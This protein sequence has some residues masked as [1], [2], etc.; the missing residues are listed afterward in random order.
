MKVVNVALLGIG[1]VGTGVYRI[2][3]E[4]AADIKHREG[5]DIRIKKILVR[6]MNKKRDLEIDKNLYTEDFEDII[7]D[8]EIDIV[9]EFMGGV[10]PARDYIVKS[11]QKGKTVVT[12]NK[13]VLA[14]HWPDFEQAAKG[15]GAGLYFEAS[16][17]GGIPII[18]ALTESLQ[19]NNIDSIMGIING[20]TNYILTEMSEKDASYDDV[21]KEAQRQGLAE[22]DPAN[23]VEGY[24]AAY[25]LSILA[26]LAFHSRVHVENIFVEGIT[27]INAQD[28]T[29][30][31]ELGYTIKLLAIGK[32]NGTVIE[33]RVHPALI[34]QTHPL[35]SVRGAY[36]AIFLH[37]HALGNFMLYGKGAGEMPTASAIVSDIIYASHI[38]E[39]K[40]STFENTYKKPSA[41]TFNT[42]W[43]SEYFI[44]LKVKDKPGVLSKISG[45]FGN[46]GVSIASMMQKQTEDDVTGI[47]PL[48]FITHETSELSMKKAIEQIKEI[49]D[50]V[51]V[52]SL[53]RVID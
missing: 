22:P 43:A 17:A 21:L 16:V 52:A 31:K 6:N 25:K 19:A 47:V 37:G 33:A 39:H 42:D 10:D 40:F 30:A 46:N 48:V 50:V 23:D 34:K 7:N 45:L 11:L 29:W 3:T 14:K 51:E 4:N 2:L 26:S 13:E 8:D 35:A 38:T 49:G 53:L 5:L 15:T 41:I 36:N 28:I 18:R 24:D 9:A 44:H 20:T 32:K 1:N 12:A 27:K